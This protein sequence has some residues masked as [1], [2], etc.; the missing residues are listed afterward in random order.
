MRDAGEREALKVCLQITQNAFEL[1]LREDS[2]ARLVI[3]A[4]AG[5]T[6]SKSNCFSVAFLS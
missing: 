6:G 3:I 5:M 4:S 2:S 1:Q